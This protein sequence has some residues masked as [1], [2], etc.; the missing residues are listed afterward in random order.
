MQKEG[1]MS[2]EKF[3]RWLRQSSVPYVS[4]RD[5]R[6]AIQVN[7]SSDPSCGLRAFHFVA[8]GPDANWLVLVG[9][10]NEAT[11][12]TMNAWA[13][14]FGEGFR[15]VVARWSAAGEPVLRSLDGTLLTL[16]PSQSA[17]ITH[18]REL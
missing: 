13:K 3:E 18:Q 17:T 4:V 12:E 9:A 10:L 16:T 8:Y 15:P 5:A 11:K 6:H 14:L 7:R 2:L 1:P